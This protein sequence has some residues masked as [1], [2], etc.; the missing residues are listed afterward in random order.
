MI[1]STPGLLLQVTV[2]LNCL[3]AFSWSRAASAAE[4][5]DVLHREN[6]V[7]WCIVPFDAQKRS[8]AERAVMLKDLGITRCAYD[9][10]A[11][12]VASFE[13]EILE[14]KKH[15]I[16][17]FAF[18][19]THEKA[20]E[21][22]EKHQIHPQ[23]WQTLPDPGG[24][25]E[26]AKVELAARQM[27]SLAKRTKA[28]NCQLGLYNHGG[29]GGEPAN[30]VAVCRRLRELGYD[31]VGIVY[32]FH[33]GHGHI[34]DW[35]QSF[36]IMKPYLLCLNLNGMNGEAQPKILGIGKGQYELEMIRVVTDSDYDGPIGILDHR[37]E[38]D[39]RKS[40]QEN[41]SGLDWVRK[42]LTKPGSGGPRP[43]SGESNSAANTAGHVYSGQ[44]S[45]RQ[46]PIT[47]ELR[48]TLHGRDQYN[49]LVASDTKRSGDHW[50]LFSMNGSGR[51]T[52]YLPGQTPDH[53]DSEAMICDDKPH[54]LGMIYEPKRVRLFVDGQVVADQAIK[55]RDGKQ[56]VPGGLAIGR[57]VEGRLGCDGD[58]EWVRI[59][60]GVR[61]IASKSVT[62]VGRD[63]T[64]L[65]FWTFE[66]KTSVASDLPSSEPPSPTAELEYN[67]D[68]VKQLARES[69]QHGDSIRGA[70][71]FANAKSACLS[72]HKVGT[73]GG[74]VGPELTSIAKERTTDQLVE[75]VLWP[76]RDVKPEFITWQ[77]LTSEGHVHTGYKHAE[78]K[79]SLTLREPASG[80]LIPIAKSDIEEEV[81]GTTVMPHGLTANMS[82]QQ[83]WDLFRFLSALGRDGQPVSHDVLQVIAHSQMHGPATFPVTQAP[84]DPE[85]WPNANQPVNRDRLYDFY[86]KQAEYF[87]KQPH[88]PMVL[89]PFPGLDGGEQGHW[90]NQNE[91][92]WADGRWNVTQLGS[93]QCGVFRGA[94]M[95][96]PRAVCVRLGID[97]KFAACFNPDTL[98]YDVVWKD[99]FVQFDAVRHGFVGGLKLQGQVLT[100]SKSRLPKE[101]FAYHGFYR[102]GDRVIFAYR[103]GD[104]EYLDSPWVEDGKFVREVAPVDEHSLSEKLAGGPTQW[105][106]ILETKI[107][108]G[109]GRPYAVDTI[110]LPEENPWKALMFCG[111]HDFLPD[112]SALVCT[113]QG[114]VW[115]VSGLDSPGDQPGVARWKRF[116][117]GLHHALGLVVA[118]G[119][120]YVQCRD[121][122]TRL[123]DQN[124]D[125]EADFYECF[126]NAFLT[127]PAGH[128]FI[129]GLQRDTDGQFYTASGNQGLVRI[130]PDGERADVIA[131]G[132]RNPD[133]LGLLA[134]GTVTVPVSEGSWTPASAINAVRNAPD[135]SPADSLYFGFGGPKGNLP[136]EL[137]LVYLPRGLDNSSGGQVAVNSDQFGPLAGQLLHFSFGAGTWFVVLRDE[138]DGQLQGALVPMTG[139]F[140]SGAHRGRFN[141]VDGQLYVSGMAGW[142]SY[143][144]RDGCFQRVRYTGDA[145]QVPI[146]LHTYENGIQITFAEPIDEAV[147][148]DLSKQFAQC[149]NYRYSGAYGSLEYSP[150]HPGLAGHDP[151]TITSAY[152]LADRR[153]LFLE[154]PDLQPVSQLHLRLHVNTDESISGNPVGN[155][156]DLFLTVHKLDQPFTDFPSYRPRTKTIAAHPL[157]ADLVLQAGRKRNP[158]EKPIPNA[159]RVEIETGKNLTYA[160][161]E[162]QVSANE[163]IGLTL[164]N[165]DVVPHNWVL[166]APGM[167][168]QVGEMGNRMIANP[169]AYARQYVPESDAIIAHT[170]IVPP[171][172]SQTI[173]F[174][175]PAKPGRYPFLCTFPGHWMVM[176][177]VMT[178]E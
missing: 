54:T 161:R 112:G 134:D 36:A 14:Y 57:L 83:Q 169:E 20:L 175:A 16:E 133:G 178:V 113:M 18:W 62:S 3:M 140:L 116:A 147:A 177:G 130:S 172:Q 163:P 1:R 53:I 119:H 127:S 30:M 38:L 148:T 84:V 29:W 155:G 35:A 136:P 92:T 129:C 5:A 174:R 85:R 51:L 138:V 125:G 68:L 6:L 145:V 139:D 165:P 168:R 49:I 60:R 50:E 154:I 76:K 47:V 55:P 66:N 58:I 8:P 40:L 106:Q 160:T 17:F 149:W 59:S 44:A 82:T 31:H 99:G 26:S 158:W 171:G 78:D 121:Q 39:A 80:K 107:T 143:T 114:D 77:I 32:N 41:L 110:E 91:T 118:D 98:N 150:S 146:G 124:N 115:H 48:A 61:E 97:G 102:H 159:R 100:K 81:A 156:Q 69:L 164:S 142:G 52:A 105:P 104:V 67:Q 15:G 79:N 28:M 128:D 45:Y 65:G 144:P 162:F 108:P 135:R 4:P 109:T 173:Y 64:T 7:A 22:F 120:V 25:D 167:L 111:A 74:T 63:E 152:V 86:T 94:G 70:R 21:L 132:F 90:G 87:R 157:L 73:H 56:S 23:I 93:V 117:S 10:R 137:P 19:S 46:P 96:V 151:L 24:N 12:H 170:D 103:I 43:S 71:V 11:E 123:V 27:E 2:L 153:S 37:N 9:W 131:T 95:T 166:V 13:Q 88:V 33:H 42:E 101:S 75:S 72:C 126:S 176:N 141:P 122:L 89:A 34:S